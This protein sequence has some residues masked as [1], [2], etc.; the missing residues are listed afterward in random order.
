M[1]AAVS[2]AI[3]STMGYAVASGILVWIM[4]RICWGLSFSALR[5]G[6]IGYSLKS[7]KQ[8]IAL[9]VSRGLQEIGPML[10]LFLA[11]FLIT[12]FDVVTIFLALALLSIPALYFALNLRDADPEPAMYPSPFLFRRPST[13]NSIT[14]VL[15]ILVDG[16]VVVVLGILF[17]RYSPNFTPLMATTLAAFYLGFRRVCLVVL[18][19]FGGWA[20]DKYGFDKV[21]NI[22]IVLVIVG[23]ALLASGWVAA[24]SAIVFVFYSISTAIT[25]GT[26]SKDHSHPLSAVSENATWRDIG[27]AVGTLI[28][29]FL[30][31]SP[32]VTYVLLF[33]IFSLVALTIR[34]LWPSWRTP[35]LLTSWK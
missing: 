35:K 28:G 34:H 6:A 13:F 20:A 31:M 12:Q 1:I 2:V 15:S 25:A 5:I 11:P 32:Y 17:L 18:S 23:L 9:G 29:G 19:P 16:I 26:V 27:A 3:L 30:I 24:G 33:G 22:S 8:G 7:P 21:F 10:S 14:L 4:L